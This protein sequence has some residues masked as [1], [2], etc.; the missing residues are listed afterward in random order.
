MLDDLPGGIAYSFGIAQN[1]SWDRDMASRGYD[2]F[3]YDHT[4]SRLPESNPRFHWSRLGLSDGS[5]QDDRLRT[6]EELITANGHKDRRDMILKIDVEGAEWGFLETVR[7]ETL[8]KFSQITFE[9]HGMINP[10]Q[11]SKTLNA[12][13]KLNA[14]H[15]LIHLHPNNNASCITVGGK[16]F[17]NT[18]EASYVLRENHSFVQ[19]YDVSLPLEVDMPDAKPL[20]DIELGQ[21]NIKAECGERIIVS[22]RAI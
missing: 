10:A 1:V 2:V 7:P 19:D 16:I 6:L 9:L 13:R 5:S 20:P 17:C 8:A 12:L 21:W 3:M 4:I 18:L 22:A 14:T 15:Q 11:P